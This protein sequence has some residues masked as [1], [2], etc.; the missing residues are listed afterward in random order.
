MARDSQSSNGCSIRF[1]HI[2]QGR[3][4]LR[5]G[6]SLWERALGPQHPLLA[7]CLQNYALL[8]RSIGREE[9]AVRLESRAEAIRA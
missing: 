4:P 9:E 2:Q 6:A 3:A 8:L 5:A 1:V 7:T